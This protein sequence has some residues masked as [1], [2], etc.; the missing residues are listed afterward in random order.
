MHVAKIMKEVSCEVCKQNKT[1][2]KFNSQLSTS[3][4]KKVKLKQDTHTHILKIPDSLHFL[5]MK[6][7]WLKE[8]RF[9]TVI[10]DKTVL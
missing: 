8:Y 10:G 7:G 5:N 9:G 1:K 4:I 2:E 3:L 6:R